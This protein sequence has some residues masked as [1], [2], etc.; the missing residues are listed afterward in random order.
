[1]DVAPSGADAPYLVDVWLDIV[2]D[3]TANQLDELV[4]AVVELVPLS[5]RAHGGRWVATVFAS[6]PDAE[7]AA[8]RVRAHLVGLSGTSVAAVTTRERPTDA[9]QGIW[10]A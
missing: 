6:A 1:M 7:A 4:S 5:T 10:H 3:M 9:A 8:V 2:P